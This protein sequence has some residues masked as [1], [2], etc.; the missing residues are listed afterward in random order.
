MELT[1]QDIEAIARVIS[2]EVKDA[3]RADMNPGR[4]LTLPEAMAYAKV[5]SPDTIRR[6]IKEGHIHAHKRTGQWIVD[7]TSIDDWYGMEGPG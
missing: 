3:V 4:W 5:R 6:W 7:R 2:R 1:H